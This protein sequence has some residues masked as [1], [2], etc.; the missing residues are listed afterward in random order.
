MNAEQIKSFELL[1]AEE[2][3]IAIDVIGFLEANVAK[4][5]ARYTNSGQ[6]DA[7]RINIS[8]SILIWAKIKEYP[9][10][11]EGWDSKMYDAIM[12]WLWRE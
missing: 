6:S 9:S 8:F 4:T 2:R 11:H 12:V 3:Q 5:I 7:N 1:S 10:P